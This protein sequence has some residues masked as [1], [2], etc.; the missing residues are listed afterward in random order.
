MFWVNKIKYSWTFGNPF[1]SKKLPICTKNS[2]YENLSFEHRK[3][4]FDDYR[5]SCLFILLRKITS[6]CRH[7]M[8]GSYRKGPS[9]MRW[10]DHQSLGIKQVIFSRSNLMKIQYQTVNNTSLWKK[11]ILLFGWLQIPTK[12]IISKPTGEFSQI[13]RNFTE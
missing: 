12:W 4:H 9:S 13:L 6:C 2:H 10:R 5:Q 1:Q 8:L 11:V 7:Y 3:P